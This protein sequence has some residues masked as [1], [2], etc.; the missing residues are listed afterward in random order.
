LSA[1]VVFFGI[2]ILPSANA[3]TTA[4]LIGRL[5]TH[6]LDGLGYEIP[7][8][9]KKPKQDGAVAQ[10]LV[11]GLPGIGPESARKLLAHFGSSRAVFAATTEALRAVPGI[12]P[13]TAAGIIAA[14]DHQPTQFHSTKG[15][16]S[17]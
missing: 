14:L 13:K 5:G 1:I 4:R 15:P 11:E 6:A 8:R 12:G 7:A 10:Y 9:V 3:M 16:P 2:A 17:R